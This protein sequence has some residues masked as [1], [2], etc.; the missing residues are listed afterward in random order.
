LNFF[1]VDSL[2]P[3]NASYHYFTILRKFALS[4]LTLPSGRS[5][6]AH[7]ISQKKNYQVA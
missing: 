2:C 1:S 7:L 5:E 6:L 4:C 3:R